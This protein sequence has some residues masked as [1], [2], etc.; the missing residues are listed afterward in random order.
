MPE[1]DRVLHDVHLGLEI[2][3]DVDRGVGD[4]QRVFVTGDV[5]HKAM[6]D[7]AGGADAR[8]ARNYRTHQL[9]G[10]QAALHQGF[11]LAFAN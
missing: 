6:A 7:A 3:Q 8:F 2:R 5:H 11:G 10:V 9:V 4:D 1:I